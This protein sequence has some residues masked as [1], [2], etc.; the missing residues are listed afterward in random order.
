MVYIVA[1]VFAFLGAICVAT[2]FL[3]LPGTWLL[4]ALAVGLELLD[5]QIYGTEVVTFGWALIG[6]GFV[7][8]VIGEGLDLLAGALGAKKGG[9][10]RRG[11]I[12]AFVGGL[13]G[14]M[15]G[16]VLLPIP[17]L[18]SLVGALLG[19]F[20]GAMAGEMSDPTRQITT[21]EA[22]KAAAAATI[23]RVVGTAGKVGIAG[24]VWLALTIAAFVP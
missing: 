22:K 7:M 2:V 4:L 20:G 1:A 21:E 8:A 16:T 6:G 5:G 11:M 24:A 13:V 12:G 9:A 23:G 17:V 10:S 14:V 19:T 3:G 18:G 15:A